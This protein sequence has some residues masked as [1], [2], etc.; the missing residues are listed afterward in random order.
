[1]RYRVYSAQGLTAVEVATV[2]GFCGLTTALGLSVLAGTALL[3]A[4]PGTTSLHLGHAWSPVVGAL[5]PGWVVLYLGW[6]CLAKRTLSSGNWALRP[7]G[8]VI[9]LPQV[10]LAVVEVMVAAGVLWQLLPPEAAPP[11]VTF[12]GV[13]ALAVVAGVISQVPGGKLVKVHTTTIEEGLYE[14]AVDYTTMAF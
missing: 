11:F 1:M 3:T 9:A 4:A 7:P 14:D 6:A 2:V 12:A 10:L 13:F 5:L 8:A